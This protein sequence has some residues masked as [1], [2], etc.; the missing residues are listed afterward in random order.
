MYVLLILATVIYVFM[1]GE[2]N[3]IINIRPDLFSPTSSASCRPAKSSK[4]SIGTQYVSHR[5]WLNNTQLP[6][7]TKILII[8]PSLQTLAYLNYLAEFIHH[9]PQLLLLHF[10]SPIHMIQLPLG[11][12]QPSLWIVLLLWH[13]FLSVSSSFRISYQ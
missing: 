11:F 6:Y 8:E 2:C 4:V 13:H 1:I 7:Y 10:I 9:Y 5:S 12:N 3:E